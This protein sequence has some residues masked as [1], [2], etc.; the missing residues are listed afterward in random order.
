MGVSAKK[1]KTT[2]GRTPRTK[3]TTTTPSASSKPPGLKKDGSERKKRNGCGLTEDAIN[4]YDLDV[5]VS[6]GIGSG[7]DDDG[8]PPSASL[9]DETMELDGTISSGQQVVVVAEGSLDEDLNAKLDKRLKC[10]LL[11]QMEYDLIRDITFERTLCQYCAEKRAVMKVPAGV[12]MDLNWK[13]TVSMLGQ[14]LRDKYATAKDKLILYLNNEKIKNPTSTAAVDGKLKAIML[15]EK[16]FKRKINNLEHSLLN[17]IINL[18]LA[19]N[20][21]L[22]VIGNVDEKVLAKRLAK[23]TKSDIMKVMLGSDD[24]EDES[25]LGSLFHT[26]RTTQTDPAEMLDLITVMETKHPD[27]A[28]PLTQASMDKY[29]MPKVAGDPKLSPASCVADGGQLPQTT[30]PSAAAAHGATLE[31]VETTMSRDGL[32]HLRAFLK[33]FLE[34]VGG[35]TSVLCVKLQA[36]LSAK[37]PGIIDFLL[38]L[39]EHSAE[40]DCAKLYELLKGSAFFAKLHCNFYNPFD[41][42]DYGNTLA[43]GYCFYRAIFQLYLREKSEY[44]LSLREMRD[45]DRILRIAHSDTRVDFFNFL[46]T[47]RKGIAGGEGDKTKVNNAKFAFFN[48]HGSLAKAFW[49]CMDWIASLHF[50]CSGF[51]ASESAG[52]G[53]W[54]RFWCSSLLLRKVAEVGSLPSMGEIHTILSKGVNFMVHHQDHFFPVLPAS[55][56]EIMESFQTIVGGMVGTMV[57]RLNVINRVD[58]AADTALS[59][60]SFADIV[61]GIK[62]NAAMDYK[63]YFE[64]A[65]MRF[66]EHYT[67]T[68]CKGDEIREVPQD[69][70]VPTFLIPQELE[71]FK[72]KLEVKNPNFHSSLCDDGHFTFAQNTRLKQENEA[73]KQ[74]IKEQK[75]AADAAAASSAAIR[76]AVSAHP[77]PPSPSVCSTPLPPVPYK[78]SFVLATPC[79]EEEGRDLDQPSSESN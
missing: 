27:N 74:M 40:T 8:E 60:V 38:F 64:T 33:V 36:K 37:D 75:K 6:Y 61:K 12:K 5:T 19:L 35:E 42:K 72:L 3:S 69:P 50:N 41:E 58:P 26:L 79:D 39:V 18:W 17:K 14:R 52:M 22:A 16:S 76:S 66:H 78:S 13:S 62:A 10:F 54:K 15:V 23:E 44:Q 24:D 49:G 63:G 25:G 45:I 43:D 30:S 1:H 21:N 47:V 11:N 2:S 71:I 46:N 31:E 4:G 59:L 48:L 20:E 51:A 68:V 65:A 7:S 57:D 29:L 55:Q 70:P 77:P 32:H 56:T 53:G 73:I 28:L 67:V 9:M 34:G